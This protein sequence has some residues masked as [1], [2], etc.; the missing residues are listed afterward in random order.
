MKINELLAQVRE[1]DLPINEFA[2]FGS[3]PMAA[4]NLREA[5]DIDLIVS[6]SLWDRLARDFPTTV[7]EDGTQKIR[8]GQ[9]EIYNTW[10]PEVGDL[11][12]LIQ[13]ADVVEGV[14]FVKLEKV[15]E[16]KQKYGRRKDADDISAIKTFL[17]AETSR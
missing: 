16:W 6:E 10:H 17:Q 7:L 3:G 5:N 4:A 15:L 9:V 1:L 12:I 8:V 13:E 11:D 2:V 14:R